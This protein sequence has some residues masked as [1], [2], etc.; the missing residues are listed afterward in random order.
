MTMLARRPPAEF[1]RHPEGSAQLDPVS[2]TASL[3]ARIS[4]DPFEVRLTYVHEYV[5]FIQSVSTL[6]GLARMHTAWRGFRHLQ[7]ALRAASG[8]LSRADFTDFKTFRADTLDGFAALS[9]DSPV[10]QHP[11]PGLKTEGLFA[12][13]QTIAPSADNDRFVAYAVPVREEGWS[14]LHA[15]GTLALQE[16]MAMAIE[17]LADEERTHDVFEFAKTEHRYGG[18]DYVVIPVAL[19]DLLPQVAPALIYGLTVVSCDVALNTMAPTDAW[20]KC[21]D[22]ISTNSSVPSDFDLA[23][24][25]NVHS[26]LTHECLIFNSQQARESWLG[27]LRRARQHEEGRPLAAYLDLFVNAAEIRERR[28]HAFVEQLLTLDGECSEEMQPFFGLPFYDAKGDFVTLRANDDLPV[29]GLMLM[30]LQHFARTVEDMTSAQAVSA[31]CPFRDS[32]GLCQ[33]ERGPH[34]STTPWLAPIIDSDAGPESCIYRAAT[35]FLGVKDA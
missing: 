5:H 33:M 15:I 3:P 35:D 1:L 13:I 17:R 25:L 16:S 11:G 22:W 18:F 6:F 23:W 30:C 34:C 2:L 14:W 28:P 4:D 19:S 31:D 7:T 29:A 20:R 21:H 26:Q 24:L 8:R 10:R 9:R 12:G 27:D 32:H